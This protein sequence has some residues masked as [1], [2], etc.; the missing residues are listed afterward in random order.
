MSRDY[1]IQRDITKEQLSKKERQKVECP[2]CSKIISRNDNLKVH[3][4]KHTGERPFACKYA[5]CNRRDMWRTSA[6][7]HAQRCPHKPTSVKKGNANMRDGGSKSLDTIGIL[8][9]N[10]VQTSHDLNYVNVDR[11]QNTVPSPPR[12]NEIMVRSGSEIIL[13]GSGSKKQYPADM[14]VKSSFIKCASIGHSVVKREL[15]LP[16]YGSVLRL[17]PPRIGGLSARRVTVVP[18]RSWNPKEASAFNEEEL[19]QRLPST[20]IAPTLGFHKGFEPGQSQG[21]RKFSYSCNASGG[22]L[23]SEHFSDNPNM[24]YQ[25]STKPPKVYMQSRSNEGTF[26]DIKREELID[27]PSQMLPT[28]VFPKP[29]FCVP[30]RTA[31]PPSHMGPLMAPIMPP[32]ASSLQSPPSTITPDGGPSKTSDNNFLSKAS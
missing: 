5:G 1:P 26:G 24:M 19:T 30:S 29:Q 8:E 4:R 14:Q 23:G 27:G 9:E 2:R 18:R 25:S 13:N 28:P 11:S 32:P 10:G 22:Y 17:E 16:L 7:N 31:S 21:P 15:D 20:S 12:S 3:M 6:N